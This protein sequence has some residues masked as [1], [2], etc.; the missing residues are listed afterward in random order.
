MKINKKQ[1]PKVVSTILFTILAIMLINIFCNSLV[2][3]GFDSLFTTRVYKK[4]FVNTE[5]DLILINFIRWSFILFSIT[6]CYFQ[7]DAERQLAEVDRMER[8]L[9]RKEGQVC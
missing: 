4:A 1:F 9:L 7:L 5:Y 8:K 6:A 3:N 2:V